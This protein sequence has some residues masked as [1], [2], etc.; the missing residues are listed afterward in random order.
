MSS[1]VAGQLLLKQVISCVIFGLNQCSMPWS[2]FTPSN[3][4]K[5]ICWHLA[6]I[7]LFSQCVQN[8]YKLSH[9]LPRSE[10]LIFSLI[11]FSSELQLTRQSRNATAVPGIKS[12]FRIP[13]L[14][15]RR[16][17]KKKKRLIERGSLQ[18]AYP[19]ARRKASV[20]LQTH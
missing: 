9:F 15:Q 8:L 20:C 12:C 17:H 19:G 7:V 4:K 6:F 11:I 14:V 13:N 10:N 5:F 2:S 1:K 18:S 16:K 3:L